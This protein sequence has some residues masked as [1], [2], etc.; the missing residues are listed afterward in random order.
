MVG[1]VLIQG[2]FPN[3]QINCTSLFVVSIKIIFSQIGKIKEAGDKKAPTSPPGLF[4][5]HAGHRYKVSVRL[6]YS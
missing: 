6:F 1:I 4:F 2:F 5:R 3:S